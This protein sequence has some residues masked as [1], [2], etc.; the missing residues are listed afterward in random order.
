MNDKNDV[1]AVCYMIAAVCS[2]V[3]AVVSATTGVY[4]IIRDIPTRN[5]YIIL[6]IIVSVLAIMLSIFFIKRYFALKRCRFCKVRRCTLNSLISIDEKIKEFKVTV[7]IYNLKLYGKDESVV[8][9]REVS[10]KGD[11]ILNLEKKGMEYKR[12]SEKSECCEVQIHIGGPLAN[13]ETARY[14]QPR[15]EGKFIHYV[16]N[17]TLRNSPNYTA[18]CSIVQETDVPTITIFGE[19]V[20]VT[21][22]GHRK[23]FETV[24]N[25]EKI[26]NITTGKQFVISGE[27]KVKIVGET[28]IDIRTTFTNTGNTELTRDKEISCKESYSISVSSGQT[29]EI[30]CKK[31]KIRTFWLD[32]ETLECMPNMDYAIIIRLILE[33][34]IVH[35]LFGS[36]LFGS[37]GAVNCLLENHTNILRKIG[38]K[39]GHYFLVVSVDREGVVVGDIKD[40]TERMFGR[41]T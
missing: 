36:G 35:L 18:E 1:I 16:S 2:G 12:I 17:N 15:F 31:A 8:I 14:M 9:S 13:K 39:N 29:V 24:R 5:W 30:T 32:G 25:E 20:D 40:Y 4:E 22:I 10:L 7:P 34:K 23:T 33:Q 27:A 41:S 28:T 37:K 21:I 26:F 6:P 38:D 3:G 19:S 11:I